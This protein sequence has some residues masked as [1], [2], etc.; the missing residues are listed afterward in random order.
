MLGDMPQTLGRAETEMRSAR[1]ALQD[2]NA[3]GAV[4]PQGRSLDYLQQGMRSMAESFMQM[5]DSAQGQGMG[6]V[7]SRPGQSSRGNDPLG[8]D[9]GFGQKEAIEGVK[10]PDE[11]DLMRSR[12]IL[13]ELRRR[14]GEFQRPPLELD[15]ID[16]L[17]RQF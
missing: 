5:F 1:D 11:M 9:S 8:R 7:G 15:Y 10:I 6:T 16:R 4:P 13:Q 14:R 2:N 12:E 17:L 3:A